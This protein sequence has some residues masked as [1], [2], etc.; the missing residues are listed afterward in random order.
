MKRE[1]RKD[2]RRKVDNSGGRK[3]I[4]ARF[5][6]N[7]LR[8]REALGLSGDQILCNQHGFGK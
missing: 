8:T 3:D 5:D 7:N 2:D 6:R 1:I 4:V